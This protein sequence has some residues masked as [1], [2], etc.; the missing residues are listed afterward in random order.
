MSSPGPAASICWL[1]AWAVSRRSKR[2]SLQGPGASRSSR[3]TSMPRRSRSAMASFAA[4]TSSATT[5]VRRRGTKAP[6]T[7]CQRTGAELDKHPDH[8]ATARWAIDLL[9]S[10]RTKRYLTIDKRGRIRLDRGAVAR[11]PN[12]MAMGASDQRRHHHHGRCR[13]GLQGA[14]RDRAMLQGAQANPD[15]DGTDVPLAAPPH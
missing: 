13:R 15:Q 12:S 8:T 1:P 6:G 11:W 4:A 9:A 3:K 14:P 2:R 5:P 7:G 10:G